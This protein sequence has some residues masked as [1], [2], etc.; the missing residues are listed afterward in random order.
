M[1][2]AVRWVQLA[3]WS[4]LRKIPTGSGAPLVPCILAYSTWTPAGLGV[5]AGGARATTTLPIPAG[6]GPVAAATTGV[7]ALRIWVQFWPP[8]L[9]RNTPRLLMP[10][11]RMR[12]PA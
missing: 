12:A 9:D 8:S 10:A 5:T 11:Y 3:P 2:V 1:P 4:V 6:G 7:A